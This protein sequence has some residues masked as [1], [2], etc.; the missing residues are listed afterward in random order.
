MLLAIALDR[1]AAARRDGHRRPGRRC[2]GS[3]RPAPA[4]SRDGPRAARAARGWRRSASHR[5]A[6]RR[7]RS[8]RGTPRAGPRTSAAGSYGVGR[9]DLHFARE[10]D[11]L[12]A[13]RRDQLDRSGHRR[14]VVLGRHRAGDLKAPD[15]RGVEQRQRTRA[16][17]AE[18]P[19]DS[20]QQILR[21]V[22]RLRRAPP[23]SCAPPARPRARGA[24]APARARSATPAR[25]PPSAATQPPSGA[26]AKPPT[27]SGPPPPGS[28]E[29]SLT[30][31]AAQRPPAL[32]H[33]GE[34]LGSLRLQ[35]QRLAQ[36][37]QRRT[38]AV[39]LLEHEPR[40]ARAPRGAHD[41][42]RIDARVEPAATSSPASA[43]PLRRARF[44]AARQARRQA[45]L[46]EPS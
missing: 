46:L 2:G 6:R 28:S 41:G 14:L 20:R 3:S 24:R 17:L 1:A 42:R 31:A 5:R 8:R 40:L 30:A 19:S 38:A 45:L 25:S 4:C 7:T 13:A 22:I 12:D 43:E 44:T 10:H 33:V 26:K 23:A 15:R 27:A 36:P 21:G 29:G 16:Q 32:G 9:V 18:A 11:L 35:A 34:A 37:G 39:G